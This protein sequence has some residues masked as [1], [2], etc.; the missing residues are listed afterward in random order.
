MPDTQK[1]PDGS[2]TADGQS[3]QTTKT[4]AQNSA[5]DQLNAAK[6]R[7]T[8]AM[9]NL[10]SAG[11]KLGDAVNCNNYNDGLTDSAKDKLDAILK[12]LSTVFGAIGMFL[13]GL[14]LL[15][16]GL[17]VLVLGG[18]LAG[19]GGL[20]VDS[21]LYHDGQGSVL[22][23]VFGALG[24]GLAGIGAGVAQ[25]A[26]GLASGARATANAVESVGDQAPHLDFSDGAFG[27]NIELGNL[28]EPLPA[29][30]GG[31]G[32]G[33]VIA[34]NNFITPQNAATDWA[35]ISDW[36]N[37]PLVNAALGK[38]GGVTPDV[39]FWKSLETQF[40]AAKNMWGSVFSDPIGF[41]SEFGGVLGGW[42]GYRDLASIMGAVDEGIS[43]L[44]FAWGGIS[45]LFGV[46]YGLGYTGGRLTG[47]IPDV[48]PS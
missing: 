17:N 40:G 37:N 47:S 19:I 9:D 4:N 43:P 44:W 35:N 36:Y 38:L 3:Q 39:G 24:I 12:I 41:L 22:D 42:S 30:G 28:D 26:K 21:I 13:A 14:A 23:V 10:T 1:N 46:G 34:T 45:G 11:T 6:A 8:N 2:L 33:N 25:L 31:Q 15:I 7:L 32:G 27:D 16:P 29:G 18:V 48:N 20:V 5:D